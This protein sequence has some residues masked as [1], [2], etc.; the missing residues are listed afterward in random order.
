MLLQPI[1]V[2]GYV[3]IRIYPAHCIKP[4]VDNVGHMRQINIRYFDS[5]VM[6][7]I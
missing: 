7:K 1:N 6:F 2:S 5:V 3:T 4:S